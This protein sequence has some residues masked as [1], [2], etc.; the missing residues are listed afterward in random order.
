MRIYFVK[1][2]ESR[3]L[4]STKQNQI[5]PNNRGLRGQL[6]S[7]QT[8]KDVSFFLISTLSVLHS[9]SAFSP[10]TETCRLDRVD[11]HGM[12]LPSVISSTYLFSAMNDEMGGASY[13]DRANT[14][15]LSELKQMRG[16]AKTLLQKNDS[17]GALKTLVGM[18]ESME[19]V[20]GLDFRDKRILCEVVDN[21]LEAFFD[22]AFT[23]PH[24]GS[25]SIQRVALGV[26]AMQLQLSSRTLQFPYNTIP[27][28]TWLSALKALTDVNEAK[29]HDVEDTILQN[30]DSAYRILQRLVTGT[31]VRHAKTQRLRIDES[32]FNMVL[33]AYSNLG[34][35]DMA[36]RIVALQERTKHAP[37][38][39]PV[40]YSILLKGYGNLGD[41][42]NVEMILAHAKAGGVDPDT[43]MLNSLINA[44]VN[45]NGLGKAQQVF[46]MM[47]NDS[48]VSELS[49][50]HSLF[51]GES[52][53]RPNQRTYNTILKGLANQGMLK[54]SIE[55]SR[56]MQAKRMWDD[57]TTNTLVQAA[58]MAYEFTLAENILKNY[59]AVKRNPV[60]GQHPNVEAY[61]NLLDGYAKAGEL[62][63]ACETMKIMK[64]RSV[65]PNEITYTCM[66]SG[67]ARHKK[68]EQAKQMI[69]YMRSIGLK[70]S[71][72]TYNS[73]ISG[74]VADGHGGDPEQF[75]RYVDEAIAVLQ[76]MMREGI[77]PNAVTIS[78]IV[79]AFGRCERPRVVEAKSL[80]SKL[81]T[82]G[83]I[84]SQ[85]PKI[86]TSLVQLYG[87]I[88]DLKGAV[89][90]FRNIQTPD[91]AAVNAFIAACSRC[92]KDKL[93][94]D[95]FGHYFRSDTHRLEPNVISYSIM[96]S[97]V[98]NNSIEGS[99]RARKLYEE[100][101][102][103]RIL[104]D[105]AL[106]DM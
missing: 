95:T 14:V 100:M 55:L 38:L 78:V 103:R 4:F 75:D 85:S 89:E 77:K 6:R 24:R 59:T 44:Y 31:G 61:T 36:H 83:I 11:R 57:V 53:P 37:P 40:A 86:A 98:L 50:Y 105:N 17:R 16:S 12:Q 39:S 45:C 79:D 25:F 96:I 32:E 99:S 91:V 2:K 10:A 35:M 60:T 101:R 106:V 71:A 46:N 97:A 49:E 20:T 88:K 5:Q 18:V 62:D 90:A 69:A 22:Y 64:E 29:H 82:Q 80:V 48:S 19:N 87:V 94:I 76:Q 41:F 33:N 65:E 34:R 47:N 93:A 52:C 63:N 30:I 8:L 26:K 23:P 68:I 74:L 51:A 104:L 27:K 66:I 3:M 70:P 7:R 73:F 28:R 92:D 54:E 84:S 72:V 102:R 9:I 43:V 21:S 58:V 15:F 1:Q 81:E 56:E 42:Q 67:L 13:S